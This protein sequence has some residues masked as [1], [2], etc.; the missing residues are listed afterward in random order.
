MG[1]AALQSTPS[2]TA[3]DERDGFLEVPRDQPVHPGND[4]EVK[5]N[6]FTAGPLVVPIVI[7]VLL[8]V[9]LVLR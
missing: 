9:L 8:Y 6:I 2:G 3:L 1:R 7:A 4:I 5:M